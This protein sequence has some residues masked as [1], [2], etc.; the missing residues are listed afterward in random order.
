MFNN[1]NIVSVSYLWILVF[2][3]SLRDFM[4][5]PRCKCYCALLGYYAALSGSSVPTFRD[6]LSIPSSRVKKSKKK[7]FGLGYLLDDPGFES[8]QGQE[9]F[10][11][12]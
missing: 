12:L 11:L 7:L 5:P 9:G 3:N 2:S 10:S 6:S 8:R 1:S 4:L